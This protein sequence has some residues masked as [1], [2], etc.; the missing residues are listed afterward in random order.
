MDDAEWK[1]IHR[2]GK[3]KL[4]AATGLGIEPKRE[5]TRKSNFYDDIFKYCDIDHTSYAKMINFRDE[6]RPFRRRFLVTAV[7]QRTRTAR[8]RIIAATISIAVAAA[9]NLR[10]ISLIERQRRLAF[11]LGG[12]FAR[13][14]CFYDDRIIRIVGVGLKNTNE[15]KNN[16]KRKQKTQ[17]PSKNEENLYIQLRKEQESKLLRRFAREASYN[18]KEAAYFN[19]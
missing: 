11:R 8:R 17:P 7:H 3:N 14:V 16:E 12:L 1:G 5:G 13:S 18:K 2:P 15:E 9:D 10:K 19:T 6:N 4:G